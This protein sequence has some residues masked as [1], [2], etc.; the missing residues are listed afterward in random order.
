MPGTRRAN[1]KVLEIVYCE[2]WTRNGLFFHRACSVNS[3]RTDA[4]GFQTFDL[5]SSGDFS[6]E[7]RYLSQ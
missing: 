6:I 2:G 5:Y 3:N 4:S 1:K 7:L